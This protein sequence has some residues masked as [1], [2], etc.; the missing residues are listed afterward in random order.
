MLAI[1]QHNILNLKKSKPILLYYTSSP[2]VKQLLKIYFF[3]STFFPD[4]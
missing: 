3:I 2:W 1:Y 4:S